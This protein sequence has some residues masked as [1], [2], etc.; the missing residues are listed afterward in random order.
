MLIFRGVNAQ[1]DF[2]A[3]I[4]EGCTPLTVQFAVDQSTVDMDTITRIDWYLGMGDTL[5]AVSLDTSVFTFPR[6]GAF[7][8]TMVLNGNREAPVIKPGYITVHRTVIATFRYE[9]YASNYNYRFVPLDTITD[10]AAT[11]FYTWQYDKLTGIDPRVHDYIITVGNQ[12]DAIDSVTLDTGIYRVQ[13][14][15]DDNYG[16]ISRSADTVQ[17]ADVIKL[18][19]LFVPRVEGFYIIDPKDVNTVL[20]I[21]VFNRYGM[22]VFSQEAKLINWDGRD[23]AGQDLNTGV[24][25]FILRSV[26]GDL[27]KRYNQ[28]GFIHLYR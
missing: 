5:R 27:A 15:I 4:T 21:E 12:L 13:L 28:N 26:R 23:N 14:V 2:T 22:L 8:I 20:K 19:N 10:T 7:N 1:P 17:I 9:E 6:E 3:D 16:C 25:Y 18:P 24:Y 11:Y